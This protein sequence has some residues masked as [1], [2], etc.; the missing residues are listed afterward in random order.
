VFFSLM[1]INSLFL[2]TVNENMH[3]YFYFFSGIFVYL[4]V[5][6]LSWDRYHTYTLTLA[7]TFATSVY[8]IIE[9]Y[10]YYKDPSLVSY[11]GNYK[12]I[13]Q[14]VSHFNI[15]KHDYIFT[16]SIKPF[17]VLMEA[18]SSG[19]LNAM[20]IVFLLAFGNRQ[21]KNRSF[22][23]L[24]ILLGFLSIFLSGSK[25][26]YLVITLGLIL[27]SLKKNVLSFS[28]SFFLIIT[29][30]GFLF[31]FANFFTESALKLYT[32]NMLLTPLNQ[33]SGMIT[34]NFLNILIGVG[35]VYQEPSSLALTEVD[36]I[37]SIIRYGGLF[38][39]IFLLTMFKALRK[40]SGGV[41]FFLIILS[42][43]AHYSVVFKFPVFAYLLL[44]VASYANEEMAFLNKNQ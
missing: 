12:Q 4:L 22:F 14:G 26:A 20:L 11:V 21:F 24:V 2:S 33:L 8:T 18:S 15:A 25:T 9:F 13:M 6:L 29:A 28:K 17:G 44:I 36:F 5:R 31:I 42:S 3:I 40:E 30:I 23:Y 37:N 32:D 41:I 1:T 19:V 39:L 38:V 16:Y 43:M 7:L 35:E 34:D 10:F 27:L